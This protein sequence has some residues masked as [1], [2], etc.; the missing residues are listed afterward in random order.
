[1]TVVAE[2]PLDEIVELIRSQTE[3]KAK[4]SIHGY[5]VNLYSL[6][7][8]LFARDPLICV[9][10]KTPATKFRLEFSDATAKN[11]HFNLYGVNKNGHDLLFTKDHIKPKSK[12]GRNALSNLQVMCVACNCNKGN[13]E[14]TR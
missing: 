4:V 8:R 7:L 11:P 14:N 1:M 5:M 10:C 9:K 13:Y 2:F 3:L 12:G 6:R